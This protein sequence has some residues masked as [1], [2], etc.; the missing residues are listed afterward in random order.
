MVQ[1]A[2]EG[3]VKEP[4]PAG[5]GTIREVPQGVKWRGRFAVS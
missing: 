3:F 1:P 5:R 2:R 4:E